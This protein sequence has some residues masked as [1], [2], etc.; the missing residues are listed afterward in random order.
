M[1]REPTV[2]IAF[3]GESPLPL[4]HCTIEMSRESG[5]GYRFVISGI[6]SDELRIRQGTWSLE[7]KD[8]ERPATWVNLIQQVEIDEGRDDMIITEK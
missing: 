1:S 6:I 5:V 2:F 4:L 7:A 8:I 3:P